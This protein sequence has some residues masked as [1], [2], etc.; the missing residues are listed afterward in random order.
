[1]ALVFP[2]NLR[3]RQGDPVGRGN[4]GRHAPFHKEGV[5]AIYAYWYCYHFIH[6]NRDPLAALQYLNASCARQQI[7]A[8]YF[9]HTY[10]SVEN[11]PD[12]SHFDLVDPEAPQSMLPVASGGRFTNFARAYEHKDIDMRE[13]KEI[14]T[15]TTQGLIEGNTTFRD[16]VQFYFNARQ[17]LHRHCRECIL[18]LSDHLLLNNHGWPLIRQ[19]SDQTIGYAHPYLL[20]K[21]QHAPSLFQNSHPKR[22]R[23][24]NSYNGEY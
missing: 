19:N 8:R 18:H 20:S 5:C 4:P 17:G 9:R 11:E 24:T 21:R 7:E 23:R 2:E 6:L 14:F 1:M 12:V 15:Q 13:I 3:F 16:A 10:P 22:T